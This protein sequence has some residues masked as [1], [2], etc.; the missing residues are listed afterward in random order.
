MADNNSVVQSVKYY[1]FGKNSLWLCIV[2]N[3]QLNRYSLDN[4]RQFT[5]TNY[6]ETKKALAA[7][8]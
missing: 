2:H 3:K 1:E 8:I 5:Y 6:G 7:P 4:T